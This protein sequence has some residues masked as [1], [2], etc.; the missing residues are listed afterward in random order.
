M[1][2]YLILPPFFQKWYHT[3]ERRIMKKII[4]IVFISLMFANIG[5]AEI[6]E[7]DHKAFRETLD[8][9]WGIL[10]RTICIDNYKFAVSQFHE[11]L[12]MVQFYEE[13]DGKSF[14]AKC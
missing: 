2:F 3:E 7:M 5:Y 14:L 10:T 9:D 1:I 11:G 13:R 12:S 6:R 8:Q 4:G